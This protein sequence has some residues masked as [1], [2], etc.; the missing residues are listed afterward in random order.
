[1]MVEYRKSFA[2]KDNK[3]PSSVPDM[4]DFMWQQ[5][6]KQKS[7][8]SPSKK[9]EPPPKDETVQSFAQ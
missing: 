3:Y 2:N 8:P 4:M 6:V 1:M 9:V 5:P 7:I